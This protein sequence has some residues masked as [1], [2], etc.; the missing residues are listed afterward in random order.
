MF[1]VSVGERGVHPK[2]FIC[3]IQL[4]VSLHRVP[5]VTEE[6]QLCQCRGPAW[7]PFSS[8]GAQHP[9]AALFKWMVLTWFC[10][11][12]A[13]IS[14][15]PV[16]QDGP[17]SV[18][19]GSAGGGKSQGKVLLHVLLFSL[20][21][22]P[23]PGC[24]S[25]SYSVNDTVELWIVFQKSWNLITEEFSKRNKEFHHMF[26]DLKLLKQLTRCTPTPRHYVMLWV[27]L[28]KR[29]FCKKGRHN[30]HELQ[31]T[32]FWLASSTQHNSWTCKY[33]FSF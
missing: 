28:L 11:C 10:C 17:G 15:L 18:Q 33:R 24:V 26:S 20:M 16:W 1:P 6:A 12:S 22:V 32:P 9:H 27:A 7:L 14:C 19:T 29:C 21:V 25:V 3:V 2:T 5:S 8:R 13:V 30:K 31:P 4:W 23:T